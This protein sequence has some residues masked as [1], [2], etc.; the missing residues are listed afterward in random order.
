MVGTASITNV[1]FILNRGVAGSAILNQGTLKL[2]GG[3]IANNSLG[4]RPP[5]L[6][7]EDDSNKYSTTGCTAESPCKIGNGHC[8]VDSACFGVASCELGDVLLKKGFSTQ[9]PSGHWLGFCYLPN[10]VCHEYTGLHSSTTSH[11]LETLL[12]TYQTSEA[13]PLQSEK[14]QV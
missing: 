3:V 11:F 8:T 10:G 14:R 9:G 4:Q 1:S 5:K 13:I 2:R 7:L 12:A 6:E